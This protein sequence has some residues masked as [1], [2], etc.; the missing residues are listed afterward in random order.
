MKDI[1]RLPIYFSVAAFIVSAVVCVIKGISPAAALLR[2]A[3]SVVFFYMLGYCTCLFLLKDADKEESQENQAVILKD[4]SDG[5][6]SDGFEE[7]EFPVIEP[8][9]NDTPV[10]G[11]TEWT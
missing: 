8:G 4:G 1:R 6:E 10:G 7:M 9:D 3:V 2:T 11:S 5:F